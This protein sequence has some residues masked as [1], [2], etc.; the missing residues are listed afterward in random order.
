M[1]VLSNDI[2]LKLFNIVLCFF[3]SKM[4]FK[5]RNSL[6]NLLYAD[7]SNLFLINSYP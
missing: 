4:Y 1:S 5:N 3:D 7:I 6:Y 2:F